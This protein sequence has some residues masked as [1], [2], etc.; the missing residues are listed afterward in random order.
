MP[1]D[2]LYRYRSFKNARDEE[3]LTTNLLWFAD[4]KEFNDPM[5]CKPHYTFD[6]GD[7]LAVA[8]FREQT[9]FRAAR[10]GDSTLNGV[11]LQNR[12]SAYRDQYPNVNE[13]FWKFAHEIVEHY[14]RD[15]GVLCLTE[16]GQCPVMYYHYADAHRG[17]CL[18]Y[19]SADLFSYVE[20]VEYTVDYP[21]VDFFAD[22]EGGDFKKLFLTKYVS[23]QYEKEWRL[24]EFS[25]DFT[26]EPRHLVYPASLLEGVIFGM[27]LP[28]SSRERIEELLRAG[29]RHVTLFEAKLR[30]GSFLLDIIECGNT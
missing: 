28:Q 21:R 8:R 30:P 23:W 10:R 13:E 18:K 3:S 19:R 26:L 22:D 7:E 2:F 14:V 5:D 27:H 6:G 11:E 15:V 17:I 16:T 29:G 9:F 4:P 25:R 24:V 12:I 1:P 20:P